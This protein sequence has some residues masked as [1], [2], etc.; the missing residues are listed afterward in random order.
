MRTKKGRKV[1]YKFKPYLGY[2]I[3]FLGIGK[4]DFIDFKI[5]RTDEVEYPELETTGID[6]SKFI[7]TGN[8]NDVKWSI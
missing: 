4:E 6:Q 7:F 2:Y 1:K 8:K 5:H 3:D